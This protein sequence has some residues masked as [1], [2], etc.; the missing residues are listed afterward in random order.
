MRVDP[1][2][3]EPGGSPSPSSRPTRPPFSPPS[4]STADPD[5]AASTPGGRLHWWRE[6]LYIGLFY[7]LYTAVRDTQG[8]AGNGFTTRGSLTAFHHAQLVIRIEKDLL[9]FHEQSLQHL[10]HSQRFF[11]ACDAFYGTAHFVVTAGVLIWLFRRQPGRYPYWR[12]VLAITT[13]LALIGFAAFPLMPP[14]L[15]DLA[16]G[17]YGFVDTL[18]RYR[19]S[20]SFDSGTMEKL[21]NQYAAMPSLHFAWSS[22]CA[23]VVLP[24]CRSWWTRT[25]AVAYPLLTAFAIVVTANH[26]FLDAV[27]GAVVLGL[28]TALARP[29]T[30]WM[31]RSHPAL[32]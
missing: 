27:G 5:R 32:L 8:S 18:A 31:R 1:Q 26:Y 28:A 6:L 10:F 3:A 14:R 16:G 4:T 11:Q 7:G 25:L 20:W 29:L 24:A 21:S 2:A 17:H 23:L 12:N 15:L 13:A 9:L 30:A 22:W 19:G